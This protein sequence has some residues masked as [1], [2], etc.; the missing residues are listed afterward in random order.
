MHWGFFLFAFISWYTAETINWMSSVRYVDFRKFLKEKRNILTLAVLAMG[1]ILIFFSVKKVVIAWTAVPVMIWSGLLLLRRDTPSG[2]RLLYFLVGT[3]MFITL[4]VEM[5]C[6][7]GDLGRMN[8]VFK[9]YS[10]G[11]VILSISA[12]C[13][14]MFSLE[15]IKTVEKSSRFVRV[16][17]ILAGFLIIGT[18]SYPIFAS[19]DKIKDRMSETAPHTLDGMEY[20]KTSQYLQDGFLMDLSQDYDAIQWMQDNI[21]GSPVIVEGNATEYKWGTR[22]TVYTGLPGVVG[23][24]YHQRQQRGNLSDQVWER[25]NAIGSFYNSVS[26]DEAVSFLQKYNVS[27]I[28]V[29]QMERG[30]YSPEGIEKFERGDGIFWDE[31]YQ[32]RDTAIYKVRN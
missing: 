30:M 19:A 23:W 8:M 21:E 27:Y 10:Q 25:V 22:F 5:F 3:G 12:A 29:G 6:L 24:N 17:N 16:W 15:K 11:W 31:I 1:S 13:A 9:L 2:K 14:M 26:L 20:M 32:E 18:L 7:H 4:F 28:L